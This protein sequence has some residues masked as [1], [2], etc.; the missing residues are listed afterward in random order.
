M[1]LGS[2][3]LPL[4]TSIGPGPGFFPLWISIGLTLVAA[5]W[6][7]SAVRPPYKEVDGLKYPDRAGARRIAT[8]TLASI[9]FALLLD[10]VGFV[11]TCTVYVA[12]L[13]KLLSRVNLVVSFTVGFTVAWGIAQLFSALG[14]YLPPTAF[15]PGT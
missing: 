12:V 10:P 6:L 2:L 8:A 1:A 9:G 11:P 7:W 13:L 14:I 3:Q 15:G 4:Y 5:F